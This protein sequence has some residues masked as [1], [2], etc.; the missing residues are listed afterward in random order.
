MSDA[1]QKSWCETYNRECTVKDGLCSECG[2]RAFQPTHPVDNGHDNLSTPLPV[3]GEL[4]KL[5]M[6]ILEEAFD[7]AKPMQE[8]AVKAITEGWDE[9]KLQKEAVRLIEHHEIDAKKN[10]DYYVAKII[11]LHT[12]HLQAAVHQKM[13][14][15][16]KSI[17][18][19]YASYDAEEFETF[20]QM[21]IAHQFNQGEK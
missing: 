16:A 20:L 7:N 21:E 15:Y 4:P 12:A 10:Y 13:I 19:R 5:L 8:L 9:E 6:S 18:T 11:E 14:D 3:D 17:Y 2:A 1:E